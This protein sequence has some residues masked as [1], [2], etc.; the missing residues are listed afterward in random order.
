M[1]PVVSSVLSVTALLAIVSFLL[2]L[3]T[4][5]KIPF[6]I[7]LAI[8]G[9]SLGFLGLL[10]GPEFGLAVAADLVGGLTGIRLSADAFL[11]LFLPPL[12]FAVGLSNDVR[13]LLDEFAPILLL[14]V[15]AVLICTLCVGFALHWV[16]GV[17]LVACLLLGAVVAA[18]DPSAV[19]AIFRD[20]GAP[21]RLV[22]LVEGESLFND[23]AAIALF[24]ILVASLSGQ[25]EAGMFAAVVQ[26]CLGIL[27]GVAVGYLLARGACWAMTVLRGHVVAEITLTV[28]LA[29]L[30]Y[31]AAEV[32]LGV[33]GV[34]AVV[35]AA[36]VVGSVGRTRISSEAWDSLAVTWSQLNFWA[37]SLIFILAAMLVPRML[38]EVTW[39]DAAMLAVLIL[40][41]LLARGLV[42]Y[43]LLPGLSLLR[44]SE[45]VDNAQRLVIL[46]GG[47]RGAVTLALALAVIENPLV[48]VEVERFVAPLATGF[49]LFTLFVNGPTLRP[50]LRILR[51]DQLSPTEIALRDRVMALS[52]S[53][54]KD[55][56]QGVAREYDIDV[57]LAERVP[58]PQGIAVPEEGGEA[59]DLKLSGEDCLRIGLL[60]LANR[61]EELYLKHWKERTISSR[62]ASFAVARTGR[63]IDAV[64][65]GGLEGYQ[66]ATELDLKL[67]RRFRFALWLHRRFGWAGPL[68]ARLADRFEGLLLRQVVLKELQWF[69]RRSILKLLGAETCQELDAELETR[70]EATRRAVKALELQYPSYA[71]TLRVR[72]LGRSALRL[73]ELD[74]RH[75]RDGS[76]VSQEVYN[77]LLR[78]LKIRSQSF[79]R[80]PQLDLGLRL[81]EMIRRVPAFES[82]P[83]GRLRDVARLLRPRLAIPGE[84]IVAAGSR[85]DAMYF[86]ASGEVEVDL[87]SGSIHL[88]SGDFFGEMALVTRK[89]R[90][91][92]VA[93]VGFCHLLVLEGRDF[94][95]LVRQ[96]PDL[97]EQIKRVAG[98]R[99]DQNVNN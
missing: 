88:L 4:R 98:A 84:R 49:V 67:P 32:A 62:L 15:I 53:T 92:N 47:L 8:L 90:V 24:G 26:F 56:V 87:P 60:A 68:A 43:G 77:D 11:Y 20:L 54:V 55:Q 17:P 30:S 7:L 38:G 63:R 10:M 69:N 80:R 39:G 31:L 1:N 83:D 22:I 21:R 85:G 66:Y 64:R 82:I 19:V 86:V 45:R 76:L 42:V 57:A 34:V 14:A 28:S 13:R 93:S 81:T 96:F 41:A 73:E 74:Y 51:L 79:R 35:T 25:G 91:A 72:F 18:T 3:A 75:M 29:Y 58:G 52:R 65:T 50:M 95:R 23:A 16:F 37:S 33:S 89:P 12:L 48:P 70:L 61:E 99:S 40:S 2:P 94:R 78:D 46:W 71:E 59:P 5:L 27:G 97:K 36:L 6:S 44:L 9:I